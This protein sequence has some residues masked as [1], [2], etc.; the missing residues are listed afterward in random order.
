MFTIFLRTIKD[1]K[2]SII[3]YSAAGVLLLWLYI[4]MFP[5]MQEMAGDLM[6]IMEG[7]PEA[8]T[9]MFPITEA[10]FTSI[11]NFLAMEQ[12]SL[13]VPILI[14]FMLVAIAGVAL[15]GEVERGT[16]EI[17]L[18][19]PV[20]R[21]KIFFARY[22]VGIFSLTVFIVLSTFMIIPLGELHNIDYV[23]K[24]FTSISILCFLFGWA[25]FSMAMFLSALFSERSRVYMIMGGMMV[26]M[27]VLQI[28]ASISD[29][30]QNI[31]YA[32]FF[33]YYDYEQALLHN[34]IT[35]LNIAI[36]TIIAIVFTLGG[37]YWF[38]RRDMAV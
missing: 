9:N 8:F 32:S 20:S 21:I 4:L 23:L 19:R 7:Y 22:L 18:S 3:I 36:F 1:R 25:I 33:Y 16:V 14:I 2:Y 31:Q 11:E 30:W 17:L 34:S 5:S 35:T 13:M 26:S 27:Y 12:Y 6:K 37:M 24:N 38:K 15:A 10:S 29:K 28:I